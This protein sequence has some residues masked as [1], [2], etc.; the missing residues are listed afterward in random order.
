M[1]STYTR[2]V[3]S[4]NSWKRRANGGFQAGEGGNLGVFNVC[5]VSVLPDEKVLEIGYREDK[6]KKTS[7][8]SM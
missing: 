4:S 1:C 5:R 7:Y 6:L 8:D 2:Y 3:R